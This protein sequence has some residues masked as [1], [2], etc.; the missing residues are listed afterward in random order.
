M[1]K[2][3]C[4]EPESVAAE[5]LTGARWNAGVEQ[6]VR[7]ALSIADRVDVMERGRVAPSGAVADVRAKI[8]D[9][10]VAYLSA[11]APAAARKDTA[12]HG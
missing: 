12:P 11:A 8:E 6:H 10:E 9:I 2:Y 4:T 5:R 7:D 1:E 3:Y